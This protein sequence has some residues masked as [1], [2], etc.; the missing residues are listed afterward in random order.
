MVAVGSGFLEVVVVVAVIV[1]WCPLFLLKC[2]Q[3][4]ILLFI[5]ININTNVVQDECITTTH[6]ERK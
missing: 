4:F 6:V 2:N 5:K 3:F 1:H